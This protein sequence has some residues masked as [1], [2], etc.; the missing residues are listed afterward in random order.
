MDRAEAVSLLTAAWA[1]YRVMQYAELV[2]LVDA[3]KRTS[4]L[5]GASGSRYHLD[6]VV[7][8]DGNPGGSVRVIGAIDDGGWRAFVPMSDGFIKAPDGSV[9]G[10]GR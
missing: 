8:W 6:I 9:V 5:A 10:E 1:R 3:P 2:A 7:C 4:E